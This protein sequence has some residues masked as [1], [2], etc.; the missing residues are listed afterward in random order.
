MP[1]RL[2]Q[3]VVDAYQVILPFDPKVVDTIPKWVLHAMASEGSANSIYVMGPS[4]VHVYDA[5]GF[6]TRVAHGDWI[7][8][9]SGCD[10]YVIDYQDF[11]A[12]YEVIP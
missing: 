1:Y 5:S 4:I 6:R 8:R 10:L 3:N 11:N 12:L 9:R 7:V 2:K